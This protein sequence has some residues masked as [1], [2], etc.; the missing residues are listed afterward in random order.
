MSRDGTLYSSMRGGGKS[1]AGFD[2]STPI[3]GY[4]RFRLNGGGVWGVVHLWYGPPHDPVTGE[5]LDRSWRWQARFNGEMIDVERCWPVC[6]KHPTT[7]EHYHQAIAR[8]LWAQVNA[9]N[10]AY[11]NPRK[12][13]DR[14]DAPLPF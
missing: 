14:I 7:A 3:A 5:E 10:S 8:Q 11:A 2:P 1:F 12:A 13:Q 6:A 4:Y 9:P